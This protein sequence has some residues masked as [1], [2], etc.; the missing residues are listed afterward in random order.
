MLIVETY[1]IPPPMRVRARK[2][3]GRDKPLGLV[4]ASSR[5]QVGYYGMSFIGG[6]YADTF[7]ELSMILRGWR[8]AQIGRLLVMRPLD[9]ALG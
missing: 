3:A 5:P 8:D 9:V 7:E 6:S 1:C 4:K 2:C